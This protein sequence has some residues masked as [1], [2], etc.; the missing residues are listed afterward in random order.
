MIWVHIGI[1]RGY[2]YID[3]YIYRKNQASG[4]RLGFRVDLKVRWEIVYSSCRFIR[5]SIR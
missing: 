5:G 3:I 4:F 2:M 1:Y